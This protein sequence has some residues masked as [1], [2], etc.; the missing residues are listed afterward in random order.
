MLFA[1]CMIYCIEKGRELELGSM[2]VDDEIGDD[3]AND[4][5]AL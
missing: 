4:C 1:T 3:G 2:D 5:T